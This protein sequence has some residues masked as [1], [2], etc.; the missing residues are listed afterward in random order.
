MKYPD[1]ENEIAAGVVPR[2]RAISGNAGKYMSTEKGLTVLI[3]PRMRMMSRL[4][5][6]ERVIA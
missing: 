1:T 6:R 2:S 3:A 4:P 5:R